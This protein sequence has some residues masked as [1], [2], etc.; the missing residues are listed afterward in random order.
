MKKNLLCLLVFILSLTLLL[1]LAVS[2]KE[3]LQKYDSLNLSAGE[4]EAIG[5]SDDN[6][7]IVKKYRA[8]W[9]FV[10]PETTSIEEVLESQEMLLP[11]YIIYND[12]GVDSYQMINNGKSEKVDILTV[13]EQSLDE[14]YIKKMNAGSS[15]LTEVA[16]NI[17][18][19]NMYYLEDTSYLGKCIYYVTNK[20]DYVYYS[21]YL[22][23]EKKLHTAEEFVELI[24]RIKD[25][26][27]Q[28]PDEEG[29]VNL[30]NCGVET[31]AKTD[32]KIDDGITEKKNLFN[33]KLVILGA[34]PVGC[35]VIIGIIF[36]SVVCV[37]KRKKS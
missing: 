17:E 26:R 33:N 15:Q 31:D 32:A 24:T 12:N 23:D 1:P 8:H 22:T 21:S 14:E 37:K 2:A 7:Q 16:D 28:Y 29:G 6:I 27:A 34:I 4:K 3:T 11:H 30:G 19:Y 9:C 25:E 10:F 18:I 36:V 35:A 20:G 13:L 5:I